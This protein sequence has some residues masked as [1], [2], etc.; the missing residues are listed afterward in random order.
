MLKL[1]IKNEIFLL[2]IAFLEGIGLKTNELVSTMNLYCVKNFKTGYLIIS[3]IVFCLVRC[4]I[5]CLIFILKLKLKTSLYILLVGIFILSF[6]Y[7]KNTNI[8]K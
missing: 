2:M 6:C 3:E 5:L 4:V 1:N 7:K 8:I